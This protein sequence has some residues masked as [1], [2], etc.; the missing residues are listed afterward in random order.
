MSVCGAGSLCGPVGFV[1]SLGDQ[2]THIQVKM[3]SDIHKLYVEI[4]DVNILN[5]Q[6]ILFLNV[7]SSHLGSL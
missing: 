3:S 2:K 4:M 5:M 1:V 6:S 7:C